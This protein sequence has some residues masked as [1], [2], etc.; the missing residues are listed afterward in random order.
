MPHAVWQSRLR[1]WPVYLMAASVPV[2]TGLSSL[3]K[4]LIF[5]IGGGFLLASVLRHQPIPALRQSGS[6]AMALL[7]L[8]LLAIS[9]VYTTSPLNLALYDLGKYGKLLLIPLILV[10]LRSRREAMVAL[11]VYLAVQSFVI[12]S[13]WLLSFDVRP[14]WVPDGRRASPGSVFFPYLDQSIMTALF[15]AICWHFRQHFPGR[16]GGAIGIALAALA[17]VN[18]IFLL[19][20]R[21]GHLAMIAVLSLALLWA[22]PVKWRPVAA[23]SP[24]VLV[25]IALIAS[26]QFNSRM[27]AVASESRAYEAG[28]TV[29]TSSGLRLN[30]WHRSV[31][32]IAQ[33]PLLGTG[34]GSWNQQYARLEDARAFDKSIT[35][36]NPHQEFLLWGVQTGLLGIAVLLAFLAALLR[37]SWHF[38]TSECRMVQTLLAV[39]VVAC[40]FNSSL[41]DALIGNYF[42]TLLGI[43]LA[44]GWTS[45]PE[46]DTL[47]KPATAAAQTIAPA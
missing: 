18:V 20:G 23:L 3:A 21:T 47:A 13:S 39:L 19:P 32:A 22:T 15:A 38:A 40:L 28:S 46:P 10:L 16:F 44:L 25:A 12:A 42:C 11:A 45:K 17:T 5:L 29:N 30:F 41:F 26:P 24:L 35:V 36:R 27:Q 14:V 9:L 43:L 4:L 31:Q 33:H 8:A 7:L 34:V 6:S 1:T 2:S 37:D